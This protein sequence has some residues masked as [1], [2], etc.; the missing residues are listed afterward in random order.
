M[1]EISDVNLRKCFKGAP[2]NFCCAPRA[3]AA[4]NLGSTCP[5]LQ[6]SSM[7]PAPRDCK[8]PTLASSSFDKH[9]LIFIFLAYDL[10][11]LAVRRTMQINSRPTE[12][13]IFLEAKWRFAFAM[14]LILVR[15]NSNYVRE[16]R[17]GLGCTKV[18][19]AQIDRPA[20]NISRRKIVSAHHF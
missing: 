11:V 9:G 18:G 20:Y 15:I 2:V 4:R 6:P 7:A 8:A 12:I 5:R 17:L 3:L 16:L 14:S 10:L 1:T 13:V 19:R